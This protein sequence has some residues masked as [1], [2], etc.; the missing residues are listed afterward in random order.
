MASLPIRDAQFNVQSFVAWLAKNG[1]E[2]GIPN[3]PYEV[4]RYR[5]YVEGACSPATHIVYRKESGLLTWTG[6]SRAHYER[7]LSGEALPGRHQSSP[8]TFLVTYPTEA[9]KKRL[10]GEVTRERLLA[11]D[12][13]EC[14]FCGRP[15]G[16]DCTIEH[17]VPKARGGRNTLA[18]YA[19][20]HRRCN[21]SAADIP[22][23][24]KIE[25]RA[26]LRAAPTPTPEPSHG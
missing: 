14:W 20:A 7:F 18:N 1:A 19:L 13:D 22:L 6:T 16:Q 23:T 3:N 24:K 10:R 26:R 11:R 15:M 21:N 25:L 12:G 5:A 4:V 8:N 9:A 17:L 2:V